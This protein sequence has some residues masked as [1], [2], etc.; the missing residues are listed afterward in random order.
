MTFK[1][2]TITL[3]L[4]FL[5]DRELY[6][7]FRDILGFYPHDIHLYQQALMH[8]S[9]SIKENGRHEN[10]ERLEFLGDAILSAVVS[11]VLFRRFDA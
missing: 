3:K 2:F 5:K 6:R 9:A 8:K 4:P 10:N 11:D 1:D 7:S